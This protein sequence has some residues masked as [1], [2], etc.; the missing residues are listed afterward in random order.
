VPAKR[1]RIGKY[2]SYLKK[3][4]E[5]SGALQ[6]HLRG[7]LEDGPMLKKDLGNSMESV[8]SAS[9]D[10][11]ERLSA[12]E[13]VKLLEH[14]VKAAPQFDWCFDYSIQT[15]ESEFYWTGGPGKPYKF[16]LRTVAAAAAAAAGAAAAAA[17]A[18]AVP[19]RSTRKSV[20]ELCNIIRVEK[21]DGSFSKEYVR[22]LFKAHQLA[23]R[24]GNL[25]RSKAGLP[26]GG[27][28]SF[29]G[30]RGAP[31]FDMGSNLVR[32][33]QEGDPL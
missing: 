5:E 8:L 16:G 2:P 17:A 25:V 24:W 18:A 28:N 23:F 15:P 33:R 19:T 9:G 20:N 14:V 31:F 7:I 12:V 4:A 29:G 22:S 26:G 13:S 21:G 27:G 3:Y 30:V 10:E 1:Q 6:D 32:L 11:G